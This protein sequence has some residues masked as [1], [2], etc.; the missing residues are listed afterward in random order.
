MWGPNVKILIKYIITYVDTFIIITVLSYQS[1][2]M[3]NMI[4][5][6]FHFYYSQW[7]EIGGHLHC[8]AK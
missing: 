1:W 8:Y 3:S 6:S 2:E 4:N 5:W 7:W